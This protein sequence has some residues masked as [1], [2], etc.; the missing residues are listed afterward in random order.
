MSDSNLTYRIVDWDDLYETRGSLRRGGTLARLTL[1]TA[2]DGLATRRILSHPQG[3]AIYGVWI[4]ILQ[5]AA[6]CPR[7]GAL[8]E[9]GVP[10]TADDLALLTS[11]PA[12]LCTLALDVLSSP[13]VA[14]LE[15]VPVEV[16]QMPPA[17]EPT[18][19]EN[20]RSAATQS[21]LQPPVPASHG[22][23]SGFIPVIHPLTGMPM[24]MF[25]QRR[26]TSQRF[27]QPPPPGSSP[28]TGR[29]R[30]ASAAG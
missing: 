28:P 19:S 20:H 7:R 22:Q 18:A 14:L 15:R 5:I 1:N 27:E 12:E 26:D 3:A 21:V 29:T 6:K 10:L 9:R 4:L 17:A 25:D 16:A 24:P 13:R 11:L 2:L 30:Q 8:V 23:S